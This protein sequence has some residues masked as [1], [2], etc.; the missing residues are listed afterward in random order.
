MEQGR[1]MA[2]I[3]RQTGVN[4]QAM[5]HFISQSPWAASST[6]QR[7]QTEIAIRPELQEGTMLLQGT[8]KVKAKHKEQG[9]GLRREQRKSGDGLK[10]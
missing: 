3:S 8:C 2:G 10:Q 6:I 9:Q 5:Q 7:M 1:S 4:E